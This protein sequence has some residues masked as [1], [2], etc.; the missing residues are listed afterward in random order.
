MTR[1]LNGNSIQLH[2]WL[3]CVHGHIKEGHKTDPMRNEQ[4]MEAMRHGHV[5]EAMEHGLV[6]EAMGH[7]QG[8]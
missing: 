1:M 4:V 8:M 2:P 3:L 6:M 7:G 5:M